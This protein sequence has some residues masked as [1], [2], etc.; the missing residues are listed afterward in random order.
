MALGLNVALCLRLFIRTYL[1]NMSCYKF[2]FLN[3]YIVKFSFNKGRQSNFLKE[4]K[5]L[6][7]LYNRECFFSEK[8]SFV[9]I[10]KY[11]KG[12]T[13]N[14]L[15]FGFKK[16]LAKYAKELQRI[17]LG[18][19]DIAA[20]D[21]WKDFINKDIGEDIEYCIKFDL[22]RGPYLIS[23][24]LKDNIKKI[25]NISVSLLHGDPS[26][27]NV[28]FNGLGCHIIDIE[29]SIVGDYIYDLAFLS[30]FYPEYINTITNS[31]DRFENNFWFRFWVYYLRISIMKIVILHKKGFTDLVKAEFRV[32]EAYR[33]LRK[34]VN[35]KKNN[36][37]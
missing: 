2:N 1:F 4:Y 32:Y 3:K 36:F 30:T 13:L 17:H 29:H 23:E 11:I 28:I 16:N 34:T 26:G 19:T 10:T 22:F 35:M 18:W 25:D 33:E 6:K 27:D 8:I 24:F 12:N 37:K 15:K 9:F 5:L 20:C 7:L 21:N 14:Q 31:Y